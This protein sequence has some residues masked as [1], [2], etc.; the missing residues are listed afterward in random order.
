MLEDLDFVDDII[1]PLSPK[2]NDLREKTERSMEDAA[3]V[4]LKLNG[5]K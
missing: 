4:G 1:A 3:R 2:F 5:N